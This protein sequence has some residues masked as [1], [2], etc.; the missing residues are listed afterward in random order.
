MKHNLLKPETTMKK[1][2]LSTTFGITALL[3]TNLAASACHN[4]CVQMQCP[5]AA[6]QNP[7][8]NPT[9]PGG[10]N[11][12]TGKP[13]ANNGTGQPGVNNGTGQPTSTNGSRKPVNNNS[14]TIEWDLPAAEKARIR[15]AAKVGVVTPKPTVIRTN[16]QSGRRP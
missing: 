4:F 14:Q 1:F 13:G 11:N 12:G 10:V 5:Q 9:N 7:S 3:A 6:P 2:L 15:E 8:T 16:V